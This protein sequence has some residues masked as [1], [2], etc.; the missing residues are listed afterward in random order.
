MQGS[1]SRI[2]GRQVWD[3]RGRPTVEVDVIVDEHHLGRGIAPAGASRGTREAVELRDAAQGGFGVR[4]A[5]ERVNERIA[6]LLLG[7]S[8]ADPAA[9]DTLICLAD[10]TPQK[11]ALG[12]NATTATSLALWQAAAAT[13]KQP[14]WRYLAGAAPVTLPMPQVQI[15]GGGAH[16]ARRVDIQ[17]FLAIPLGATSFAEAMDMIAAVYRSAGEVLRRRA[18]AAGTADEGGWWPA[19]SSNEDALGTLVEAIERAGFHPGEDI[20]I[21]VDVAA[22]EFHRNEGYELALEERR[23][24]REEWLEHLSGWIHRYPIVSIEDPFGQDDDQGWDLFG[25]RFCNTLQVI[26]DDYLVTS[27][28]RVSEAAR[29]GACN[30]VLLKV[31]QRGTVGETLAALQAAR[32]AG[33]GTVVSA[34]SGESEDT[35]IAHLAV[36]WNAGQIKVGSITRG[37]RTAKWNELL[38]IEESLGAQ[39]VFAGRSAVQRGPSNRGT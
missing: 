22:S 2:I 33:F 30:A 8:I 7:R 25:P 15:F 18:P 16:A 6:P 12:G 10:G 20:G 37:E 35:A 11:S 29:R 39:A 9:L 32:R 38:R 34:R 19:F 1:I 26:G 21:A 31:N 4:S 28:E 3:S 24:A 14:L 27:A 13:A 36:G 5:V 23:F 17:D